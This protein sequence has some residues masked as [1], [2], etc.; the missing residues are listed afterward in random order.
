MVAMSGAPTKPSRAQAER[1]AEQDGTGPPFEN[2][3][4]CVVLSGAASS[5]AASNRIT[6]G[7]GSAAWLWETSDKAATAANSMVFMHD[8]ACFLC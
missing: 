4:T 1:G 6:A 8:P 5:G 2:V 7:G 3:D